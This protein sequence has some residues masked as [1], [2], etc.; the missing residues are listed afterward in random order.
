M[1][2]IERLR[3]IKDFLTE[4]KQADVTTLSVMLSVSEP[5]IRKDL[6]KLESGGIITRFHGGAILKEDTAENVLSLQDE[7]D[8][9]TLEKREI[10]EIAARLINDGEVIFLGHGTTCYQISKKIKQKQKLSVITNN[11]HILY[12]LSGLDNIDLIITGG[13]VQK[14]R[15]TLFLSGDFSLDMLN[16][17]LINKAFMSPSGV[18]IQHGF[19]IANKEQ[20]EFYE[21]VREVA[22]ELII[23]ADYTK[24]DKTSMIPFLP[25]DTQATIIT[26]ENVPIEYKEFFFDKG[27]PLF[28]TISSAEEIGE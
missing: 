14:N 23:V 10:A 11:I 27:I 16:K 8:H 20:L 3:K 17:I 9:L 28:T 4:Y 26:N 15:G 24:F 19:T 13:S 6:E 18:N 5:T 1:L 7:I 12:E 2:S 25:I 22:S 21:K